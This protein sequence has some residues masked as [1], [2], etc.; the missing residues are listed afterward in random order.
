MVLPVY[1][2]HTLRVS[3][4]TVPRFT[5][6]GLWDIVDPDLVDPY[7]RFEF[8]T[9]VALSSPPR[10]VTRVGRSRC[11]YMAYVT[12]T[13]VVCAGTLPT[14]HTVVVKVVIVPPRS[15]SLLDTAFHCYIF[16][17]LPRIAP[18]RCTGTQPHERLP[19]VTSVTVVDCSCRLFPRL[20]HYR[21]YAR[22]LR[23]RN[24]AAHTHLALHL[25]PGWVAGLFTAPVPATRPALPTPYAGFAT[26]LPHLF[27]FAPILHWDVYPGGFSL[28]TCPFWILRTVVTV[29]G[30]W[31]RRYWRLTTPR[32]THAPYHV[33]TFTH[34]T[35]LRYPTVRFTPTTD[36]GL[37][38]PC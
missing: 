8:T 30:R 20:P 34:V 29:C 25:R 10:A 35:V 11:W 31:F 19:D 5:T 2:L 13:V 4:S 3:G 12:F 1:R 14:Y 33:R 6:F 17:L 38:C 22:W 9:P 21:C 16:R 23:W 24:V 27:T 32:L 18:H 26:Y 7:T 36:T 37:L 28:S 15:R